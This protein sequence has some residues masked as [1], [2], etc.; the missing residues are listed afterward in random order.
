M[1]SFIF[2]LSFILS[3]FGFAFGSGFGILSVGNVLGCRADFWICICPAQVY[4]T[5]V[6][7]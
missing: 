6:H 2:C 1:T 3:F 4:G 7:D 5:M